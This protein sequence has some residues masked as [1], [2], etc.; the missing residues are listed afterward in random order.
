MKEYVLYFVENSAKLE[1]LRTQNTNYNQAKYLSYV[2]QFMF[3]QVLTKLRIF[4]DTYE[5]LTIVK[6]TKKT[7]TL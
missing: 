4:N 7:E 6:T 2:K 5:K 3:H 1:F